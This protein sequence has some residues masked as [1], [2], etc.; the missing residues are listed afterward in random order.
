MA[1]NPF[2]TP[3]STPGISVPTP[4]FTSSGYSPALLQMAQDRAKAAQDASTQFLGQKGGLDSSANQ[5][6]L[7]RAYMDAFNQVSQE[8]TSQQQIFGSFARDMIQAKFAQGAEADNPSWWQQG[9]GGALAGTSLGGSIGG[10]AGAGIGAA[11]GFGV[12]ALG[13]LN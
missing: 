10:P 1:T 8:F 13:G 5:V 9:L 3:T 12:G 4:S 11:I 2:L 6:A 7:N